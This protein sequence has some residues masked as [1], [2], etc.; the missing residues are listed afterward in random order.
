MKAAVV[1]ASVAIKW[2][3][4]EPFS[5]QALALLAEPAMCAP[6]HWQGEAANAL[7]AQVVHGAWE[8]EDAIERAATLSDAPIEPVPLARLLDPALKLAIALRIT[9]YDSLYV[10][11]AVA[12]GIP[13]VSD[14]QK[15]LRRMRSDPALAPLAVSVRDLPL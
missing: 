1:D 6:A 11:L 8:A 9:V 12:R 14:D 4:T 3:I 15:L 7:W 5:E 10:A 2:V 13:L